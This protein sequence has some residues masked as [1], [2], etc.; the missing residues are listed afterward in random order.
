MICFWPGFAVM[1]LVWF[2]LW[3]WHD[4]GQHCDFDIGQKGENNSK[5]YQNQ[6]RIASKSPQNRIKTTSK[7]YQNHIKT[8]KTL[9]K[10]TKSLFLGC[11]SFLFCSQPTATL[12]KKLLSWNQI[13]IK[14][15]SCQNRIKLVSKLYQNHT[16]IISK[17][18]KPARN[19]P[20]ACPGA[21]S[22][23]FLKTSPSGTLKKAL[24][25]QTISKPYQNHVQNHI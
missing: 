6:I 13:K 7:P 8:I 14:W 19:R 21:V 10:S 17:P 18:Q 11:Y 2:Q 23:S 22:V 12:K 3:F 20:K 25:S 4:M 24:R 5:T 16:K 15:E 9:E 1:I